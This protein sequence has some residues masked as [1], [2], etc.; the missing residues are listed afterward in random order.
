MSI[1][2]LMKYVEEVGKENATFQG[3]KEW[4]KKSED[5]NK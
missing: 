1:Y 5:T 3:L 2:V 4:N